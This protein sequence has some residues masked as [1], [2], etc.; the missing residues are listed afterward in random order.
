MPLFYYWVQNGEQAR[1]ILC[2]HK[3]LCIFLRFARNLRK[4]LRSQIFFCWKILRPRL[5]PSRSDLA[6]AQCIRFLTRPWFRLSAKYRC[7][8]TK[9]TKR[10]RALFVF[11]FVPEERLELSPL[12]RCDFEP[13]C[14][15]AGRAYPVHMVGEERLELS[16]LARCDFE[17]HAST[18]PPLA[19]HMYRINPSIN[20]ISM[21]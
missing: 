13:A 4:Y 3:L 8:R 14:R 16:P 9:R 7:A 1:L 2:D 5:A 6:E 11:R 18:I 19:L 12:A 10:R 20:T 21:F 17:S 15:Q